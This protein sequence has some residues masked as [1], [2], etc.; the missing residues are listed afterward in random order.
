MN[1]E[2]L[3]YDVREIKNQAQLSIQM[4]AVTENYP[5]NINEACRLLNEALATEMICAMRYRHHQIMVRGINFIEISEEFM[6]HAEQEEEH[7]IMIAER[8]SQL[9]GNPD[10]N[11]A[12]VTERSVC[13]YTVRGGDDL[14]GMIKDDLIAERIV[15]DVYRKMI[16]WFG[17]DDPTTRRMLEK[18]L[19]D[20]EEH[21]NDLADLLARS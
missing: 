21:A 6:E 3:N 9:G 13:D 12:T 18:I 17:N 5:L 16:K 20:E 1:Q 14:M 11:P 10:L 15:I 2:N 8:I 7:M 19:E 4:G